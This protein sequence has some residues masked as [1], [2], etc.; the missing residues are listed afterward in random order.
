MAPSQERANS[1]QE[2]ADKPVVVSLLELPLPALALIYQCSDAASHSAIL[3]A[4]R[5][6]RNAVLRE[7]RSVKLQL[8]DESTPAARRPLVRLLSRACY[9]AGDGRL[10]LVLDAMAV[11]K[12]HSWKL[13]PDLLLP[14][15]QANGW[16]SVSCLE[17]RVRLWVGQGTVVAASQA[18]SSV[19]KT[20]TIPFCAFCRG[21]LGP[22]HL[23]SW[24]L[25]P[26]QPSGACALSLW[27]SHAVTSG[28]CRPAHSCPA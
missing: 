22:A 4:S 15:I 19:S 23:Q 17:L 14:A 2:Q 7:A 24:Q 13:L 25:L 27:T 10:S 12:H 8:K 21:H 6:G 26:S 11:E 28:S 18:W 20:L 16:T 9:A 1:F 3:G 5:E